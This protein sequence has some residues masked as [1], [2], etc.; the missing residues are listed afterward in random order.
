MFIFVRDEF[1]YVE[2]LLWSFVCLYFGEVD[3]GLALVLNDRGFKYFV[4]SEYIK[5]CFVFEVSQL[6]IIVIL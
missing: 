4:Y 6:G 1:Q 2:G 3:K 5:V